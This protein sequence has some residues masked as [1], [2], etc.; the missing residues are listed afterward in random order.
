MAKIYA[1]SDTHI[2]EEV[3]PQ[4][5]AFFNQVIEAKPDYLIGCGD[6]FE[7]ARLGWDKVLKSDG[8]SRMCGWFDQIAKQDIRVILI[9]GNHDWAMCKKIKPYL[10]QDVLLEK[11]VHPLMD[12]TLLMA[13]WSLT[14]ASGG[15][16]R[17]CITSYSPS[18][19]DCNGCTIGSLPG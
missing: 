12:I 5:D 19:Q 4:L 10:S 11:N 6:I 8:F 2:K 13:G 14:G 15:L 17:G 7:A 1:F 9:E 16:V 18:F 3:P